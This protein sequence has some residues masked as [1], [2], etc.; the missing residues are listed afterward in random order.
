MY[1]KLLSALGVGIELGN[2]QHGVLLII[3]IATSLVVSGWRA[4]RTRRGWPVAI[5][6]LGSSLVLSGHWGDVHAIE[7]AGVLV[8]GV[9]GF[10]ESRHPWKQR[11]ARLLTS[12]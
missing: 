8:L 4:L 2:V 9:G 7:W 1:G 12:D 3:A 11:T 5:A 6:A 10:A